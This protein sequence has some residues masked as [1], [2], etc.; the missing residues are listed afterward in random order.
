MVGFLRFTTV[1]KGALYFE[2]PPLWVEAT[3]IENGHWT[4]ELAVFI[5][6]VADPSPDAAVHNAPTLDVRSHP[7]GM[8]GDIPR[9]GDL[10]WACW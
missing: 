4:S 3:V 10:S 5:L 9:L 2:N 8:H 1:K 7:G 6:H